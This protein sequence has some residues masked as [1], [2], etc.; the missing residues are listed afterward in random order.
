MSQFFQGLLSRFF[1]KPSPN[2]SHSTFL[3][4]GTVLSG[5]YRID[6]RLSKG[7]F[8]NTYQAL[9]LTL[10]RAVAIKEFY[11][12]NLADRET[13][14]LVAFPS[15]E[16][17]YERW[18]QRFVRE[19]KILA[20]LSHPGIVTVYDLFEEWGTAY[21]VM[22]FLEGRTLEA[23]LHTQPEHRFSEPRVVEMITT[24]VNALD[25]IHQK[26]IYHLD[27]KPANIMVKQDGSI[28]LI[29]FGSAKQDFSKTTRAYT[30]AYAPPELFTGESLGPE[31]DLFEL[32]MML[33]ELLTGIRPPSV[34]ER[35]QNIWDPQTLSEPWRTMLIEALRLRRVH[36]PGSVKKWWQTYFEWV[37]QAE[38]GKNKVEPRM[39]ARKPNPG[40]ANQ[41]TQPREP[42]KLPRT[43]PEPPPPPKSPLTVEANYRGSQRLRT[44]GFE[45]V[46]VNDQGEIIKRVQ[47]QARY[48]SEDLGNGVTLEMVAIPAGE[49][50]MGSPADEL[51]RDS[52]EDPQHRVILSAFYMGRFQVTQAQWQVVMGNN[53]SHFKGEKRPV[54]IISWNDAQEFCKR[55]SQKTGRKYRLPSEAE[56]EYACRAGTTTPFY[57]G[58]TITTDLANYRGTDWQFGDRTYPGNYGSGPKGQYREQTTEVGSFPPNAFGLYDMHGNVWE[59]CEDVWHDSYKGAPTDGSA[60]VSGGDSNFRLL[61]GGSWDGN[62]R[63]CRSAFRNRY[64]A[65]NRFFD[66]GIR[67]VYS[68][69]GLL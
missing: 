2:V 60:W 37:R 8:G 3:A 12:Q 49:F 26:G 16:G 61:H 58:P 38:T 64:Y 48:F 41:P 66:S 31:S 28:V 4:E 59:W 44:F 50:M 14:Q 17:E 57:F 30:P 5:R 1:P 62:P 63:H 52:N 51:D 29:D 32:G 36:R 67:V 13:G 69:P 11:P 47:Q 39:E 40:V 35:D 23:E 55:L 19:G 21:M 6:V 10:E 68:S 20:Q 18:L 9:D 33:H 15:K 42:V 46:T 7:G 53:P 24:L 25:T 43:V 56:W 27:L 45:V 54:E 22:E 34:F 65:Y